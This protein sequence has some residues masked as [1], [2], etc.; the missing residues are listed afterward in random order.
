[1]KFSI[2]YVLVNMIKF[3]FSC[4]KKSLIENFI[5]LCE[6][7]FFATSFLYTHGIVKC[8]S[9]M[10]PKNLEFTEK[11]LKPSLKNLIFVTSCVLETVGILIILS[12]MELEKVTL[13]SEILVLI[14]KSVPS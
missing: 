13:G 1:M 4:V 14:V 9:Y 7:T 8:S 5:F 11:H 12:W 2:E 6:V 10:T 3:T